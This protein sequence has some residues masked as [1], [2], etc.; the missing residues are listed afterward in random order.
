MCDHNKWL[1]SEKCKIAKANGRPLKL[2]T[3]IIV[4]NNKQ[5]PIKIEAVMELAITC[6]Y[7]WETTKLTKDILNI[8]SISSKYK[9]PCLLWIKR[10]KKDMVIS[11]R[12][13]VIGIIVIYQRNH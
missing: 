6:K 1:M 5:Q 8:S 12:F 11:R 7:Q 4:Q 2:Y 3:K 9:C 13:F 10:Y